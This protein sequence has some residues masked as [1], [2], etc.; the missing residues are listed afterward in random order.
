MKGYTI[1]LIKKF[2][3]SED[4]NYIPAIIVGMQEEDN[5]GE[6]V[7]FKNC[8]RKLRNIAAHEPA[9]ITSQLLTGDNLMNVKIVFVCESVNNEVG[10]RVVLDVTQFTAWM[11][12]MYL[13]TRDFYYLMFWLHFMYIMF[14][15]IR[16]KRGT[17]T[18]NFKM[19]DSLI[20]TF[21]G[22]CNYRRDNDRE[23]KYVNVMDP[24]TVRNVTENPKL[25]WRLSI[26][27]MFPILEAFL[28]G[29]VSIREEDNL[30][31]YIALLKARE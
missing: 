3:E 10:E 19:Q 17:T 9:T 21:Q 1:D 22:W 25:F 26:P 28:T 16:K 4:I 5:V 11:F 13:I 15:Y 23:V 14:P 6:T 29:E 7:S 12:E 27:S 24:F 8:F 31:A 30:R 18:Y 2:A 20:R